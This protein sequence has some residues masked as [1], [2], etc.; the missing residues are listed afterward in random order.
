[1]DEFANEYFNKITKISTDFVARRRELAKSRIKMFVGALSRQLIDFKEKYDL[2]IGSGNSGLFMTKIASIT[3]D[4]LNIKAPYVLNLPIYRFKEDGATLYD[5]SFLITYVKEQLKSSTINNILFLDDEIM[6]GITVKECFSLILKAFPNI[7]HLNAT[8]I[9]ENHFFEWHYKIPKV[10]MR[11][12]AYSPLIQGL[13]GNI[14]YFIPQNLFNEVQKNIPE[15]KSY[16][17]AMAIVI[18]GAIKKTE[19]NKGHFDFDIE[20]A[21]KNNLINY[22]KQKSGLL[23]EL[24]NLVTEGVKEYKERKIKFRF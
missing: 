11:F 18:G 20:L 3:Y 23:I 24:R 1:M 17:Q 7:N 21:L 14:G 4:A 13:N 22:E 2:I 9:A 6:R 12:F 19:N 15:V 10:S 16:N 8:I 5:N